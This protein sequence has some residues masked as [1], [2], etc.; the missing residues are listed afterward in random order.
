[1][2]DFNTDVLI[3]GTGI[4]GLASAIKLAEKK[5]RYLLAEKS[6]INDADVKL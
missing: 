1:M 6:E 2:K 3:I 4:A 5:E